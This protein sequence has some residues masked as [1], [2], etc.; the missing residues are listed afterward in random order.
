M[1]ANGD[2]SPPE[3]FVEANA[4]AAP[5]LSNSLIVEHFVRYEKAAVSAKRWY[6][7]IGALSLGA[8]GLAMTSLIW[9]LTLGS[10]LRENPLVS[11]SLALMGALA[12]V[13]Q[14]A[15]IIWRIKSRWLI[16]R[17]GAERA[18][19]IKFEAFAAA[20]AS[21]PDSVGEDIRKF[22]AGRLGQLELQLSNGRGAFRQFEPAAW[23]DI[24]ETKP[25]GQAD[26]AWLDRLKSLY[27]E[28]RIDFQLRHIVAQMDH[29]HEQSRLPA[30][31]SEV[32]FWSAACVS[33]FD[34]AL[35]LPLFAAPPLSFLRGGEEWRHFLTLFLFVASAILFV[36]QRGRGDQPA[37]ER[38]TDLRVALTR[39]AGE[40]QRA[41]SAQE[42]AA[43]VRQTELVL[44]NE[45][46]AFMRESDTATYLF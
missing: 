29:L 3:R 42:F 9:A 10:D 13:A 36:Y 41:E 7:R 11:G 2:I 32:S 21:T 38:Y 14:L 39:M 24:P 18:R 27:Q 43:C 12:L 35:A 5:L 31:F 45:L 19:S 26:T 25:I 33:F 8:A 30:S 44:L 46:G 6:N 28:L 23:L 17:F 20:A 4:P 37:I 22:T 16:G 34:L 15:L 40:V 1:E